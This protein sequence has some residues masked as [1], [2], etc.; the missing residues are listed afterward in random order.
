MHLIAGLLLG[1]SPEIGA[2]DDVDE[3]I[4]NGSASKESLLEQRA[5]DSQVSLGDCQP[6]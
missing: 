6:D 2:D 1:T 3:V 4:T 5:N